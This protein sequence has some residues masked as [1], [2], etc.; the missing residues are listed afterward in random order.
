[1]SREWLSLQR[2]ILGTKQ[3]RMRNSTPHTFW[4][5]AQVMYILHK[6]GY[7]TYSRTS[8]SE[9][10]NYQN[11]ESKRLQKTYIFQKGKIS[12]ICISGSGNNY[13]THIT[14]Q[15]ALYAFF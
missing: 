8:G 4:F 5:A 6:F 13:S 7:S 15:S 12:N 9:I 10:K 2:N 11:I 3:E 1:M 14:Y